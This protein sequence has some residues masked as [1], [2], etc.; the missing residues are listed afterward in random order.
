MV[1]KQRTK[2]SVPG[3]AHSEI[4]LH[5]MYKCTRTDNIDCIGRL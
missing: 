3:E 5:C 4:R 2:V 1:R